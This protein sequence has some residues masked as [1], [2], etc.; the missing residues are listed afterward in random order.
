MATLPYSNG[1]HILHIAPHWR[2]HEVVAND[3]GAHLD[4]L[5]IMLWHLKK[6]YY[7][8][9][10]ATMVS[11]SSAAAALTPA[12]E[13]PRGGPHSTAPSSGVPS[14]H[15]VWSMDARTHTR[16]VDAGGREIG[17]RDDREVCRQGE[18]WRYDDGPAITCTSYV[19]QRQRCGPV[20]RFMCVGDVI[21]AGRSST[22][23]R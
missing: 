17:R 21:S 15:A 18:A 3:I 8:H 14:T 10:S 1:R 22:V 13:T 11:G 6:A 16:L 23:P 2:P 9:T 20:W 5:D 12:R 7:E 4:M 19:K